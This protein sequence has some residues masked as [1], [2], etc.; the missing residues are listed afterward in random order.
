MAVLLPVLLAHSVDSKDDTCYCLHGHGG[1]VAGTCR[2]ASWAVVLNS[3]LPAF[4][5]DPSGLSR[6]GTLTCTCFLGS[7]VAATDF[8]KIVL[9]K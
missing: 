6:V 5:F 8:R 2:P 7:K 9:L 1:N 4:V 3:K